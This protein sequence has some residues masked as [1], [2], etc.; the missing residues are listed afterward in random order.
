MALKQIAGRGAIPALMWVDFPTGTDQKTKLSPTESPRPT[1]CW[2]SQGDRN[3]RRRA[4]KLLS[5]TI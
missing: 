5:K 4:K 1:G 2:V 3:T